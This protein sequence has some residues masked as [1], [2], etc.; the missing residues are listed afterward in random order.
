M[1]KSGK[2]VIVSQHYPPDSNTTAAIMS[3]IAEHLAAEVPVLILSG[4]AGSATSESRPYESAP[5]IQPMVVEI[6]NWAPAKA[7]LIRRAAAEASFTMRAFLALLKKVQRGDVVL[8][9]TAPFT[10]PYAVAA[11]ARLKHAQSVLIMHD[12]YP[13]VLVMAGLL[14]ANSIPTKLMRATNSLMFRALNAVVTIGRDT[15]AQLLRYRG[16]T[17]EKIWFIPNWA[18]LDPGVRPITAGN[19]YR[20]AHARFVVGLSGNLGFTHDPIIVFDAAARLLQD[21]PD[22]HFLLSGWGIGFDRLKALQAEA[23]LPNV[24]VLE[25]VPEQN[26][27]EFLSAADIWL[28]PYLRNVAGVSVPSRFYN[29]LAIGRPVIIISEPGAEAA[30]I[31]KE[32][33]LGWVVTPGRPYE[34][35]QTIRDASLVNDSSQADRAATVATHFSFSRAMASYSE[36]VQK[37]LRVRP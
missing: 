18:T 6:K 31:V 5:S 25:R 27:E 21:D 15:E 19:R 23:S 17:R 20:P 34:L 1:R 4:T 9:V 14:R 11:A 7:A 12:L 30:L 26:L 36:L 37:L 13:E 22:I 29:L 8:T 3:A 28:I 32:H 35:A 16:M 24:T 10:L 2:V 33:G